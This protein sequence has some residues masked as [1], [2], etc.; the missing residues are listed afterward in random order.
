MV[1]LIMMEILVYMDLI[2]M[3]L[4]VVTRRNPVMVIEYCIVC[5]LLLVV[6]GY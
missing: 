3:E 2:L 1:I 5:Y 6:L 4:K